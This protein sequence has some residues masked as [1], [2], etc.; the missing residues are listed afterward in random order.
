MDTYIV[1]FNVEL[2]DGSNILVS[3]NVLK[4]IMGTYK[5]ILYLLRIGNSISVCM[6]GYQC[7]SLV[8]PQNYYSVKY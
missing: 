5:G 3:A 4:Q 8:D 1:H 2:K 7:R 6:L